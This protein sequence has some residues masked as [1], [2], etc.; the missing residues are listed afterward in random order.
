MQI[1]ARRV[2]V[3]IP[4]YDGIEAL[5]P[6]LDSLLQARL[7][8]GLRTL[9]VDDGSEPP[10]ALEPGRYDRL[11]VQLARLPRNQGIVAALN[12][13]LELARELGA[14]YVARLDAGDTI[15]PQ[16]LEKQL[17]F[18]EAHPDVGIV[19]SD[20]LFVDPG[21]RPLFRFEA[22]RTDAEARRRMHINCCLLH[23]SVMLRMS[24]LEE[25]GAYS[26]Q[27]PAAEDYDLFLRMLQRSRAAAIDEP[28]TTAIA[29]P[30]GITIRR[31]RAQL[32]SRLRLQWRHFDAGCVASYLGIAATLAFFVVPYSLVSGLKRLIGTSRY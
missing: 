24:V 16:R 18:L 15:H 6:T 29:A 2:A 27:Y 17:A 28:L 19:S 3:L 8:A 32:L 12:R 20:V 11:G 1:G 22:P 4:V 9:I 25:A 10:I 30:G 13:G 31:R 7:P 23:A 5:R 14:A 26:A 21:G